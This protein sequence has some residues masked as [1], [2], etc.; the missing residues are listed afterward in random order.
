MAFNLKKRSFLKLDDFT[1]QEI[2]FLLQLSAELK[3][4]TGAQHTQHRPLLFI[5]PPT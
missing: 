3:A 2:G 1:S 4:W 5:A